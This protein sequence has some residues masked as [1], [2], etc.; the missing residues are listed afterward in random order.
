MSEI[1]VNP[2]AKLASASIPSEKLFVSLSS[3]NCEIMIL[4][5][6]D[7]S[8]LSLFQ[9]ALEHDRVLLEYEA[10]HRNLIPGTTE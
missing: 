1:S 5:Q 3:E 8:L 7:V 2:A 6:Y 9:V 10:Y 4:S